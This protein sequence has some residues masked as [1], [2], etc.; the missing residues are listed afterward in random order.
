MES[1]LK[2]I[3]K[4]RQK[5]KKGATDTLLL[6]KPFALGMYHFSMFILNYYSRVREQLKLDYD[7]FMIVQTVVSHSLYHLNKANNNEGSTYAELEKEW[8]KE[9]EKTAE[10]LQNF[11]P[12]KN[13]YKLTISS[14]CLVTS[15]PKETVRRKTNELVKKK[16]LK[17]SKKQGILLGPHYKKIFQGYVP[18]TTL[19]VAKLLKQWEKTGILK[20]MLRFNT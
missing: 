19:Q 20:N 3:D 12:K 11:K 17:I 16:L 9:I 5:L 2:E 4:V 1:I 18:E 6:K 13:M 14:I 7:S 10:V 8:E 15:L